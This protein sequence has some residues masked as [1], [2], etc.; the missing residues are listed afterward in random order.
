M[1]TPPHTH[2]WREDVDEVF[3]QARG[4]VSVSHA[5]TS[6]RPACETAGREQSGSFLEGVRDS[7]LL[8]ALEGPAG[9]MHSWICSSPI[10][11]KDFQDM[12]IN[13]SFGCGD[14][15]TAGF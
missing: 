7:F 15:E 10:G 11:K 1:Q 4:E 5:L 2:T 12:V 6:L 14:H 8:Q 3:L 9:V 13:D